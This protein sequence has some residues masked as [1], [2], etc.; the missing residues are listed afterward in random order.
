MKIAVVYYSFD[1]NSAVVAAQLAERL[2]ADTV[3]LKLLDD[4]KRKGFFKFLWGGA[5]VMRK[6][7]PALKPVDFDP[8]AYDLIILG[9]PVWADSPA[10]PIRSFLLQTPISGKKLA[11]YLC[12]AGGAGT[13]PEKLKALLAGNEIIGETGFQSPAAGNSEEV[14]QQIDEWVK[15]LGVN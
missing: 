8:A 3:R 10:P 12:Y 15:T 4:K 7:P 6:K 2:N 11:F 5:M 13:A 9:A 1:G 14:K